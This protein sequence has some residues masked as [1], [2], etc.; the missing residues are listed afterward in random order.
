MGWLRFGRTRYFEDHDVLGVPRAAEAENP[1]LNACLAEFHALREEMRWLRE[2]AAQYQ[3]FA[4][5]LVAAAGPLIGFELS[6]HKAWV[7][8]TT[9]I[10][11]LPFT[12]LGFLFFH[13]H[14]EVY[15]VAGYIRDGIKPHIERLCGTESNKHPVLPEYAIWEW[16]RYKAEIFA[17]LPTA[18]WLDF[19]VGH[20]TT[21]FMRS[22]L[23]L[24]PALASIA[25]NVV[26]VRHYGYGRLRDAYGATGL[27]LLAIGFAADLLFAALFILSAWRRGDFARFV[28]GPLVQ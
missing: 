10:I 27:T 14:L 25:A 4:L 3:A 8:P 6:S 22:V 17:R 15:V 1:S 11:P 16:E 2:E 13:Q 28:L 19:A 24:G 26:V 9:V 21:H 5:A 12:V 23:F 18:R 20:R 7:L